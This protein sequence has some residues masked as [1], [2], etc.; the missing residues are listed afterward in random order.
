[1]DPWMSRFGPLTVTVVERRRRLLVTSLA[2]AIVAA[3]AGVAGGFSNS[4]PTA[5]AV[6]AAGVSLFELVR[7][8]S[9]EAPRLRQASVLVENRNVSVDGRLLGAPSHGRAA[10]LEG[11]RFRV[12]FS[13][14]RWDDLVLEVEGAE[15]A[16][17][18]LAAAGLDPR[19]GTTRFVIRSEGKIFVGGIG[20]MFGMLLCFPALHPGQEFLFAIAPVVPLVFLIPALLAFKP[21]EI[22]LG[23]DGIL[24]RRGAR[25]RLIPRTRIRAVRRTNVPALR[26][27]GIELTLDDGS[28]HKLLGDV[29]AQP[30]V[31]VI[32]DAISRWTEED[33]RP[34]ASETAERAVTR[35]GRSTAEWIRFVRAHAVGATG[36]RET[37]A[38][39]R[40]LTEVV[41]DPTA[42]TEARV[43]AA[44][45]LHASD[46]A[47]ALVVADDVADPDVREVLLAA[48]D[49]EAL[50]PAVEAAISSGSSCTR[51]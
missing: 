6:I 34:R 17:A 33:T 8:S 19:E 1:M 29:Y 23:G 2:S 36:Y 4:A 49:D 40:D 20:F 28:T 7:W 13:F 12:A 16:R 35:G 21:K 11:G 44:I 42:S 26:A 27:W 22:V 38:N 41:L 25:R 51:A 15:E 43:G 5:I 47:R 45:A 50:A 18:L 39:S 48:E 37:A 32:V 14:R 30:M 31:D 10:P 24:V 46:P 3:L 9:R